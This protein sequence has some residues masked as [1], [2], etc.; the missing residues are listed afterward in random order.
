M[1]E[2]VRNVV[3]AM[4]VVTA[5]HI[6]LL[7]SERSSSEHPRR[8]PDAAFE[9]T[10]ARKSGVCLQQEGFA[11][12]SGIGGSSGMPLDGLREMFEFASARTAD[13]GAC[14]NS[15][16]GIASEGAGMLKRTDEV[17]PSQISGQYAIVN[18]YEGESV[19]N[20]GCADSGG[21]AA[22]DGWGD[23]ASFEACQTD[24]TNSQ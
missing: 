21:V 4:T 22:F 9:D 23:A 8:A 1:A 16:L 20:G 3:L 5:V 18:A 12:K 10:S 15:G 24:G 2:A 14:D 13:A 7:M 11:S 6:L 17:C 19:H